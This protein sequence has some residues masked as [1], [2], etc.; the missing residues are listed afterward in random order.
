MLPSDIRPWGRITPPAASATPA[1]AVFA[2]GIHSSLSL[3]LPKDKVV[4]H[5]GF[6]AAA[7]QII[8]ALGEVTPHGN[9]ALSQLSR[10]MLSICIQLF[11][12]RAPF[13]DLQELLSLI[14]F[15]GCGHRFPRAPAKILAAHLPRVIS[16]DTGYRTNAHCGKTCTPYRRPCAV[17]SPLSS[18]RRGS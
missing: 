7:V 10:P 4:G 8:H 15:P 6:S 13:G 12:S 16:K 18:F 5:I 1:F 2:P 17:P 9:G 11:L 3:D 14:A